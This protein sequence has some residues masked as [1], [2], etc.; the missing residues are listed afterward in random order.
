MSGAAP[1]P[2]RARFPCACCFP[3]V[4]CVLPAF[5][6]LTVVPVRA[7]RHRVLT[8]HAATRH[9]TSTTGD[10]CA[11]SVPADAGSRW[12]TVSTASE[13]RSD[14]RRVRARDDRGGRGRRPRPR[15]GDEDPRRSRGLFDTIV[16]RSRTW[17]VDGPAPAAA[18]RAARARA[19]T[20]GRRRSSSRSCSRSLF[21]LLLARVPGRARRARP[22]ARRARGAGRGARGERRRRTR[23]RPGRGA[24]TCS[25][26]RAVDVTTPGEIGE[27]VVVA[28]ALRVARPTLPLVGALFPDPDAHAAR[29]DAARAVTRGDRARC[30]EHRHARRSSRSRSCCASASRGS[31]ARRCPRPRADTAADAAALA[32]GR[33]ARARPRR[34]RGRGAPPTPRRTTTVPASCR[35]RARGVAAEVVVEIGRGRA[36]ARARAEVDLSRAPRAMSPSSAIAPRLVEVLVPVAALRRLHARRAAVVAR[37]RGDEVERRAHVARRGLERELGDA[38]AA[39][40]SRRTRRSSARRSADACAIDTPPTSQRSQIVNS[41]SMPMSPCSAACTVPRSCAG[42]DARPPRRRRPAPCTSTRGSRARAREGRGRTPRSRGS[43]RSACAGTRST[44]LR[45]STAPRCTIASPSGAERVLGDDRD[46]GLGARH[47]CTRRRR[48]TARATA[49]WSRGVEP[50]DAVLPTLVQVDRARVRD[51]E[52][53]R[54]VDGA[55]RRAP[56]R[57]STSRYSTDDPVRS[58]TLGRGR[59]L[60]ATS[61]CGR[62]AA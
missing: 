55:D 4:V 2:A 51:R 44:W 22:G 56:R 47:A 29:G 13:S 17:S 28:R 19:P 25:P 34:D 62:R 37:A 43:S 39:R 57:A 27:P 6:L 41:G 45:T 11:R 35:A 49:T 3:L 58:P 40:D 1:K 9:R 53:A 18:G 50:V 36:R 60:A 32:G 14:D 5:A 24:A 61:T 26:V 21:L 52:H 8:A 23:P 15:V 59:P 38:R 20:A 31:A 10:R 48:R 7:R 54:V 16:N 46:V 12:S 30:G 42:R 33:S